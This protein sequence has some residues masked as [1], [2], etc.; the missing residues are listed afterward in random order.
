MMEKTKNG[1]RWVPNEETLL[2]Q[3]AEGLS[4]R[5]LAYGDD[6]MCVE[7][8]FEIGAEG[9]L[10]SHPH[11]QASYIAEG[12]FTFTVD[13]ETRTVKKGDSLFVPGNVLHGCVCIEK[14]IVLDVFTPMREDFV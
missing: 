6:L 10:H 3:M 5:I 13:G 8:H 12:V 11:T 1:Q 4:R 14:G 9:K 2:E 7:N